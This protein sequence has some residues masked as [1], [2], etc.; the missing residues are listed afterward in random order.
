MVN[1]T[2]S[3]FIVTSNVAILNITLKVYLKIYSFN[4]F[5]QKT[6]YSKDSLKAR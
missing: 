6:Y 3:T 4:V 5:K 1:L 2:K